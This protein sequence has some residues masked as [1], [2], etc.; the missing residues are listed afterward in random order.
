MKVLHT[1]GFPISERR[2]CDVIGLQRSTYRYRSAAKDQTALRLRLRDLAAAR[3]RYGYRRLYVLVQREGWRVNYTRVS[4]LYRLAALGVRRKRT[5]KRVSA[6]RVVPPRVQPPNERWSRDFMTGSLYDGRRF[7]VLTSVDTVPRESPAIVVD[8]SLSGHRVVAVLDGLKATRGLPHRI[9]VDNGPECI[10][11]AL[12]ARAHRH[13]VQVECSRPGTPTD[14]A[15]NA[16]S[17]GR[18]RQE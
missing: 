12:D 6:A 1:T 2:A 8:R 5:R 11:K 9:A 3:V 14:N 15:F 13:D 17:N 18:L 4:H 7:R 16:A 10:S